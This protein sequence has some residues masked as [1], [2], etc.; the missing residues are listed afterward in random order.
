M[1]EFEDKQLKLPRLW[2]RKKKE[3]KNELSLTDLWDTIRYTDIC[4]ISIPEGEETEKE[5]Y[6]KE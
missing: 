4:I 1:R 6:L 5:K 2:C 3:C